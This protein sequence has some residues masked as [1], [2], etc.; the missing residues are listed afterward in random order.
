MYSFRPAT[1][2]ELPQIL[3]IYQKAREFMRATG[4]PGQWGDH[5]PAEYLLREDIAKEQLMLCMDGAQILCVFA[6]IPGVDPTYLR[7]E[8]G[9]WLNDAPYGVIHRMAVSRQ[10]QGI[11]AVCFDWA[12]CQCPNLRIDTHAENRPMQA[13]LEKSGFTRCGTIYLLNGDPRIAFHKAI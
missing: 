10:G 9:N 5:H 11:A 7:I 3:S 8:D 6:Y 13:A 4:N 12:L 2:A 1:L